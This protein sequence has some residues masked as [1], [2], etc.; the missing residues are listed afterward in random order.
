METDETDETPDHGTAGDGRQHEEWRE[1]AADSYAL[2]R[3]WALALLMANHAIA[4]CSKQTLRRTV[5]QHAGE[6]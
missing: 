2:D 3:G 4:R 5:P 1:L 6:P